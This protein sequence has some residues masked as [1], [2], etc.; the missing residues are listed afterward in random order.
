MRTLVISPQPFFSPRG[1]PL[2]V[3]Y[4]TLVTAEMGVSIDLLTYGQG[5]DVDLP[6]VNIIRIPAFRM[7][8]PVKVGPSLLKLFL[9]IFIFLYM[10]R[11]LISRKYDFVHAHEE[12]GFM[13]LFLKPI[14]RFKLVYDMHSSLP[15][16]LTNFKFTK[17]RILIGIF[18]KLENATLRAADAVITI[19]E[20]LYIYA[21]SI[22]QGNRLHVLI[23]N[24]LFDPIRQKE[25]APLNFQDYLPNKG[26]HHCPRAHKWI[27]YTGTLEPYQ[28]MDIVVQAFRNVQDKDPM[29]QLIIAG[30]SERQV[31][32]YR[33]LANRL[34]VIPN[35][36]FIGS[37]PKNVANQLNEQA[38]VVISP[39]ISGN[40]TPLK[41]Y[42]QLNSGKPLV[43]TAIRSHTQVL[44]DRVAFLVEPNPAAMAA[45]ILSALNDT[46]LAREK[47]S[48]ARTLYAQKYDQRAYRGK[49]RTVLEH[50]KKCAA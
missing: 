38:Q 24:S 22:L 3:Y 9:D 27:V 21:E 6:N 10:L 17:S 7:L 4:R 43:A 31:R 32:E 36:L 35:C 47:V 14:F 49:L 37:V 45:G 2:S 18:E 44:D 19:C 48:A 30:G 28:G 1:T 25:S 39:R 8:G 46:A 12:A 50:L 29:A 23:E 11:L 34:A 5:E 33:N 13:C 20:D 42:E 15:Q 40:N 16:Q 26:K 41:I